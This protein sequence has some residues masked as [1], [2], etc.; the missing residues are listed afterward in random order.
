MWPIAKEDPLEIVHEVQPEGSYLWD[1][2]Q[3]ATYLEKL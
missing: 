3:M 2:S 1:G